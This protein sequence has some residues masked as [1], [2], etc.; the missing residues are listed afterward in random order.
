M[1]RTPLALAL[2]V[3]SLAACSDDGSH[4]SNDDAATPDGEVVIDAPTIDSDLPIDAPL[5]PSCTPVNGTNVVLAPFVTG[6]DEPLWIT[7]PNGDPRQFVVEQTGAIRVIKDGVLLPSAFLDV[8]G[9]GG[10]LYGGERGLLGLA[11]HPDFGTNGKFYVNFTRQPDG[12]TVIAEFHANAG[13][14]TADIASRRDLLIIPQPFSNHNGGWIEFSP[15]DHFLY[16]GMGDGGSGGDPQDRAQNDTQLLGKILRIDVDTR[17]GTK[18]YGIPPSNPNAGSPDGANDPRPEIWHK[19]VRNP[20]RNAFD[21]NGD[22][23]LG[24]VGQGA[25]EEI[26]V[27]SPNTAAINWGWDDRE[28]R[29]CYEPMNG[30]LTAGRTDPVTEHAATT[31]WHAIIGG[32]VYRGTCFPGLVGQYFY[33]D[34]VAQELWAFTFMNGAAANDRRLLQNVG[35]ITAIH[36]DSFGEIYVVTQ[37]GTVRHL[38]AQ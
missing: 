6:L 14:D 36:A 5:V 19:G 23:Y 21:T 35:A 4:P 30:C 34:Y 16:I 22:L 17:T 31:N 38:T 25:W 2:A 3:S 7:S 10:V 33:G 8:G 24:D 1:R 12:A 26:D 20:F 13:S 11:F 18:Q 9:T 32:A 15:T 29:H 37:N 28:G 27:A